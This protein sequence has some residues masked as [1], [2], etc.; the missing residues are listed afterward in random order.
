MG[1]SNQKKSLM[2]IKNLCIISRLYNEWANIYTDLKEKWD[3]L[4]NISKYIKI[5]QNISK[6]I[7]IYYLTFL[8]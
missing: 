1:E 2:Y 7:K 3:K 5:Y 8:I 6:Y 4:Y